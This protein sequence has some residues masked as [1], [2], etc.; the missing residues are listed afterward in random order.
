MKKQLILWF[1]SSVIIMLLFPFLATTFAKGDGGMA[2][3]FLLFYGI[4]PLYAVLTGIFAGRTPR[5]LWHLPFILA[6]LFLAGTWISFEMGETSFIFYATAY[7][8]VAAFT[9]L[10]SMFFSRITKSSH[11]GQ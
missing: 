5:R 7:L 6:F 9:M 11:S 4:N 10:I 3:C 1:I 2:I 8:L